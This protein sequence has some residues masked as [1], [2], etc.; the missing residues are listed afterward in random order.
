[1]EDELLDL[2]RLVHSDRPPEPPRELQQLTA[3][4]AKLAPTLQQLE[5]Y[6]A[7]KQNDPIEF[8]EPPHAVPSD[9]PS[10]RPNDVPPV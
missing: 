4:L 1:M 7:A 3:E 10:G 6:L 9:R 8:L 2:H 5:T